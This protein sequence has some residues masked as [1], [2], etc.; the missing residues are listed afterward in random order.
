MIQVFDRDRKRLAVLENAL[1]IFEDQRANTLWY[2]NF[3]L[4]ADDPKNEY[5]RPFHLIR[6]E[7]GEL[8]RILPSTLEAG[9][10]GLIVYQCEHVLA[11]LLDKVLFGAH[12]VGNLGM[13]TA[14]VLRWL[15][16]K[17]PE[18]QWVLGRC[19][20]S[21]QF[22]YAWEQEN[23]LAAL[24]SVASPLAEDYLWTFDTASYPWTLN[25]E[26]LDRSAKPELFLRTRKNLLHYVRASDP[27]QLC[28]RL[29]PL[30]Y[31]E[32]VNQLGVKE[33]NGGLPYLQSPQAYIDRYGV[34]ERV[35]VDRRYEDANS[36]LAAARA[37][38][39]QLQEPTVAYTV[40]YTP[41]EGDPA[42]R[43]G[44]QVQVDCADSGERIRSILTGI[45]RVSGEVPVVELTLANRA[46]DIA[47]TVADLADRQRIE[48]TY[49]QGATQVYSQALQA[50]CD[51]SSGAVMDFFIPAEMRIINKVLCKV[52]LGSFR[53]YS[54]STDSSDTSVVTSTTSD[55]RSTTSDAG[56]GYSST[57]RDGGGENAT[58]DAGGGEVVTV[59]S[60]IDVDVQDRDTSRNGT[61]TVAP[62]SH[63]YRW[64]N[65][66][67]HRLVISD[68]THDFYIE[69]H[70]HDFD[71]P[72]H[73]HRFTIPGHDHDVV[74][75]GHRHAITPGIYFFG[76]PQSFSLYVNGARKASFSAVEAE[77]DLTPY[78]TRADKRIPRGSWLSI[79]VR[80]DDL[81]YVSL[82]LM[83]QGFVQS[84]GDYTV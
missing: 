47:G 44:M 9:E 55:S 46:A 10:T 43:V 82:D 56:G 84:R 52:R 71:I 1:D 73:R 51:A 26:R 27:R 80:P 70:A 65:S 31:G 63:T 3:S 75:P 41:V 81:A 79:E 19:D 58:S 22:E 18:K 20:F 72:D 35:W 68:H 69:P 5:C 8:Y 62:H 78:L 37:M 53:S 21:R 60:G 25:L 33:V 64:V 36:L 12:V 67:K 4:P 14:D 49:A 45:K 23:L 57:S 11:T 32:G 28:T 17:Q 59:G 54:R 7:G 39:D 42:P 2:L 34:L 16:D 29:Y 74:I 13:P 15:L 6:E 76:N 50:N 66:H 40:E 77:L 83:V 48:S 24:F 38:L 61:A 30:G